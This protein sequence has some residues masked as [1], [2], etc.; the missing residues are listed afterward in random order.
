[1]PMDSSR[2]F[3]GIYLLLLRI[4]RQRVIKIGAMGYRVFRR[5][6]YGYVGVARRGLRA[7]LDRHRS[8]V[9]QFHWHID[10]LLQYGEIEAIVYAPCSRDGECLL[11]NELRPLLQCV[12]GFGS[13]D[14]RCPSHLFFSPSRSILVRVGCEGFRRIGLIPRFYWKKPSI[15]AS[16]MS[17]KGA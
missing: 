4:P 11:A 13:S 3:G 7:R 12:P 5:G 15:R 6:S 14:C 17:L 10:Y 9:K 8:A 2:E 16:D 1:M